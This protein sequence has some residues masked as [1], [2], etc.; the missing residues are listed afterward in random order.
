MHTFNA[1]AKSLGEVTLIALALGVGVPVIFGLGVRFWA[2][3]PVTVNGA[4]AT[5]RNQ[6]T[7][8]LAYVLFA[9]AL[10]VVVA[11]ILYIAKDFISQTFDVQLFGA[12]KK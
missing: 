6:L 12:K 1:I 4:P 11:G 8:I 9:I 10:I 5:Q 7:Q 3:E 2:A